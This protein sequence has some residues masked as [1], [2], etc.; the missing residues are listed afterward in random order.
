M[1]FFA[2]L[3]LLPNDG[4][5]TSYTP[6]CSLINAMLTPRT[7]VDAVLT[8]KSAGSHATD[9]NSRLR[10]SMSHGLVVKNLSVDPNP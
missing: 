8:G 5:I 7:K 9:H 6:R 3:P 10:K 1:G 2:T 4:I